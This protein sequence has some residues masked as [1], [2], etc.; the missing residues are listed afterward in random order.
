MEKTNIAK[1]T[2]KFS[3]FPLR[4][5]FAEHL[6]VETNGTKFIG[7]QLD[8]QLSWKI[9]I[10]YLLHKLSSVCYMMRRLSHVLNIQTLMTF[11]IFTLWLIME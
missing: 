4:I 5:T 1:F 9:R 6:P 2:P 3:Y 8:S 11:R 10:N 7:L